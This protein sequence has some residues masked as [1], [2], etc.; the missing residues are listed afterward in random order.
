MK[1]VSLLPCLMLSILLGISLHASAQ[2]ET[3]EE[4][5]EEEK[6][7]YNGRETNLF[8]I[9]REEYRTHAPRVATGEQDL[10]LRQRRED[11]GEAKFKRWEWFWKP[12]VAPDGSFPD[13]ALYWQQSQQARSRYAAKGMSIS[14]SWESIGPNQTEGGYDG[15][16]RINAVG[17]HPTDPDI[18]WVCTAG[19]G[20]WKSLNGGYGWIPLTDNQPVLGMSDIAIN[21]THPDS[22]YVL[23]GDADGGDTYSIGV[24]LSTDG[25]Y[26]FQTT[27][28]S[29]D[30]TDFT[31]VRRLIMNPVNTRILLTAG[32]EGVH[33]TTDAGQTWTRVQAGAFKDIEFHP[34]N[35]AIVYAATNGS[36]A[37]Y[38]SADGGA[39]WTLVQSFPGANRIDLAISPAQPDRVEALASGGDNGLEGIYRSTDAGLTFT[40]YYDGDCTN[41][42]LT[43]G[44]EADACGGQGWYDLT[45]AIN[46]ANAD[47]VIL[48]GINTW[49]TEDGG[50]NWDLKTFWYFDSNVGAQDVHAD[51]HFLRYHPTQ[52]NTIYECNDGGI[53]RSTDGGE[54][55]EDL[56]NG[57]AIGQVYKI[58]VSQLTPDLVVAGHQDN[59]TRGLVQGVWGDVSG[60]DGMDCQVDWSDDSWLYA[61]YVYG[62]IYRINRVTNNF[63]TISE[64]IPG[65]PDGP[66]L[67]PYIISPANPEVIYA[68][69]G[70]IYKTTDRGDTWTSMNLVGPGDITNLAECKDYPGM[71]YAV[72]GGSIY[73]TFDDGGFWQEYNLLATLNLGGLL[74][75]VAVHPHEPLTAWVTVSGYDQNNK[76]L[77]TTDGGMTWTNLTGT[78]PNLPA[79]TLA[80][81]DSANGMLY[82]GTDMGIFYRDDS[83]PDWQPFYDGLPNVVVTDLEI[84]H[85]RLYAATY[86][87]GVWRS[88]LRV[89]V[90]NEPDRQPVTLTLVPNPSVTGTVRLVAPDARIQRYELTDLSGKILAEGAVNGLQTELSTRGLA[91][92]IYLVRALGRDGNTLATEKLM[93]R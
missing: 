68:G 92:G 27:G 13:P 21:P 67:T 89:N 5:E 6:G 84:A 85:S 65:Q 66:W 44:A 47:H 77:R 2:S 39:T 31:R 33:R 88:D 61:S 19:G 37:I 9:Q 90:S 8:D 40:Q 57:M 72:S 45:I 46:P 52:P 82:V 25:G 7:W 30:R 18:L 73:I 59:G 74:S 43:W 49:K 48:G 83:M 11:D 28:L 12:R 42:L 86:G 29:W 15:L 62:E 16:G 10:R 50:T 26:T 22:I 20:L 58:G 51:K 3:R 17:F 14:G 78:L 70:D 93:V 91:S 75:N 63:A 81:Q 76:V 79:N 23:T 80:Y 24:L 1:Q 35:P 41:N 64:N 38:R 54:T 36:C 87:R 56:S 60:G 71:V 55:W 4:R 34:T 32:T 53:Y 69:Y